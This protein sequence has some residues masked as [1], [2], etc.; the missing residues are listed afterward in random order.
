LIDG[1]AR[2]NSSLTV[3][4]LRRTM[5]NYTFTTPVVEE[6]PIGKHRLF[7]FYKQDKGVSIAKSGGTYSKVRYIL[8]EDIA[9]YDEFYRGGYEH[10]VDDTVKAALIAS[11]LGI[12]EANFTVI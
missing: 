1:R 10:T 8:D 12:T 7:Y 4:S 11:G 2:G 3:S 9:D 5:A 6:A